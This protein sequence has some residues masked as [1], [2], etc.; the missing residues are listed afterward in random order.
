VARLEARGHVAGGALTD[1]GLVARSAVEEETDV[2]SAAPFEH[3]GAERTERVADLA[4]ALA[5]RLVA[6]GAYP[7]GVLA[8][9]G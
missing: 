7:P 4:G 6:A 3:L 2:L 1:A 5:G 8:G 9:R